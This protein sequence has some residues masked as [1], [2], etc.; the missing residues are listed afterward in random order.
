VQQ[1]Q[2]PSGA[3]PRPQLTDEQKADTQ[4]W[5]KWVLTR[6]SNPRTSGYLD[7]LMQRI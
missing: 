3:P 2:A 5:W 4:S 7:A 6:S 1:W